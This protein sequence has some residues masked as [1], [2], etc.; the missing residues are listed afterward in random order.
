MRRFAQIALACSVALLASTAAYGL[1]WDVD[2]ADSAAY[3][4]YEHDMRALPEGVVAQ[5][6]L[7]SP[8]GFAP[9]YLRGSVE[10]EALVSPHAE[11]PEL[12]ATGATMYRTYCSPCHGADGVTLGPVAQPG[13]FP[14]VVPLA[15]ASGV[16]RLRSDGWI[17]LT[18][19]N[20]SA[21]MPTY[22]WAMTDRELWSVVAYVRTLDN[23]KQPIP[24]SS[25]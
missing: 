13:R 5:P 2:M 1:P 3:K 20:G 15:G 14:G 22:G 9:N 16:A 21:L 7:T 6:S 23:A 11:T 25:P 4:A 12:Q 24:G 17:Y 8:K 18:A 19:R 10:G